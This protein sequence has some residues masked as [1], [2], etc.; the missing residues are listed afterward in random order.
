LAFD[1][2]L[3]GTSVN[4]WDE[5]SDAGQALCHL[6]AT[7]YHVVIYPNFGVNC[8][9]RAATFGNF[10]FQVRMTFTQGTTTDHAGIVFRTNG[11]QGANGYD[12]Y[13]RAD[14]RYTLAR[15][16]PNNCSVVLASG[17]ASGFHGGLHV[18]NTIAVVAHGGTI[19]L[20]AN[21]QLLHSVT[22]SG[23]TS[24][25]LG[26]QNTPNN[27]NTQSEVVYTNAKA[28]TL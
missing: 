25:Y 8:Y 19:A 7:G 14:G 4:Q 10:A 13:M 21:G 22:D 11:Q 9:T 28:W 3:T 2:P 23:F 1:D 24:G 16:Q 18:S 26:V 15:C 5:L 12:Y 17:T 27:G 20:Y 6:D